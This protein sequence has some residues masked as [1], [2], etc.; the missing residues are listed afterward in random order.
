MYLLYLDGSGSVRNPAERHFVLAGVAVFERQ[1]YHLISRTDQFVSTLGLG[2][3]HDVELH[4]S[5]MAN[6]RKSPWKGMVRKERL[7]AIENGLDVLRSAHWSVKAF[8]VAVDKCAVSPDDPVERAFEEICNRF[9][10]FLT[11]LWNRES[12]QH[13]GLVVMDKSH[14]EETLQGLARRFRDEGT[15]WGNLRNLAEVP[16]FVDSAASRLIQIADLLAWAVWRRYEQGDTRY[17][18][19]VAGRFDAEGGVIHGLVHF[20]PQAEECVCPACLS[21]TLRGTIGRSA[22]QI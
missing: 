6:G 3:I 12:R 14:Y 13:R 4:A 18:D 16:L 21:R 15:R 2:A 10:L 19:R 9:N 1:I 5:V 11:R 7:V 17:F 22:G 8:A 20:K